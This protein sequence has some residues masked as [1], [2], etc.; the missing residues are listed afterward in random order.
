MGRP[1]GHEI[2]KYLEGT[3]PT[4]TFEEALEQDGLFV[5]VRTPGE[6]SKGAVP[7]SVN[8]PLFSNEERARIGTLYKQVGKQEAIEEGKQFVGSRFHDFIEQFR[9]FQQRRLFIYCARGGMRSASVA[10]LMFSEGFDAWQIVGGYKRF[11]NLVLEWFET[12][13]PEQFI[14]LHGPTG[15]GKTL[16]LQKLIPAIDLEGLAQHRS[17][18]FGGINRQPRTQQWFEALLFQQLYQLKAEPLP[19][20][21]GESRKVGDV[22]LPFQLVDRMKTSRMVLVQADLPTRVR[23]TLDEYLLHDPQTLQSLEVVINQLRMGLSNQLVDELIDNLRQGNYE[24]V[25]ETLLERYYDPKYGHSM[26]NY[27]FE[28]VTDS[29]NLEAA[30]QELMNFRR[31]LL[32]D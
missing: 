24:W 27:Q 10:K 15:V 22:H 19:F 25:A 31:Q 1:S 8:L 14:V 16:L 29:T 28:K 32:T 6:W 9:P 18:L 20:I 2:N 23:R 26:R 11:R 17:S 12:Q 4:L 30:I 21:E 13:L 5:D 7:D 3:G